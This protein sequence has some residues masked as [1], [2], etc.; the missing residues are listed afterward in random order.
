MNTLKE[1]EKEEYWITVY[2]MRKADNTEMGGILIPTTLLCC[3]SKC[4]ISNKAV[5]SHYVIKIT[6][7]SVRS[8]N[9]HSLSAAPFK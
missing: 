4:V 3:H 2:Q 7:L 6:S 5:P 1:D 9:I 8:Q